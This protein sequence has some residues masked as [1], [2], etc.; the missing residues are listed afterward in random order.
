M[1]NVSIDFDSSHMFFPKIV[2]TCMIFI[3]MIIVYR[4]RRLIVDSLRKFSANE[5][6]N[7]RNYKA[8]LFIALISAYILGM[9]ALG[10]IFP[11]TGYAF[12]ILTIPLMFIIPLLI[13]NEFTKRKIIYMAINAVVSPIIAWVVLGQ[14]FNITL[15]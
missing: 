9:E 15:P 4:E 3:G 2:I 5:I 10:E 11:N 1:L 14:L 12:L 7:N 6:I 13:E 8:Y